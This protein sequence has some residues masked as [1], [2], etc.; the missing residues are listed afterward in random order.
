MVRQM[1][2]YLGRYVSRGRRAL[3]EGRAVTALTVFYG[4]ISGPKGAASWILIG[5]IFTACGA[6][7]TAQSQ[8]DLM[9]SADHATQAGDWNSC[10][11]D[12]G[13]AIS[14]DSRI[15]AAYLGRAACY[16]SRG[17]FGAAA[18]DYRSALALSPNDAG[19]Y[20]SR[21]SVYDAIGNKTA[22]AQDYREVGSL[23]SANP[24]QLLQAAQGLQAI[25][26]TTEAGSLLD[27]AITKYPR[28]A[29]L[30]KARADIHVL[31]GNT[32]LAL[33]E[34]SQALALAQGTDAASVL[35]DR[36]LY[37]LARNAFELALHDFDNALRLYTADYHTFEGRA[38]TR[39][40]LGDRKGAI[41]DLTAAIALAKDLP[42]A[43][44]W[45]FAGLLEARAAIY[46]QIR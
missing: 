4:R 22:A 34:W 9:A 24:D 19:L 30:H 8:Q 26:F 23:A 21:A 2:H 28:V 11:S 46:L 37:Y 40:A 33:K 38:R 36:G 20:L 42:S 41:S 32:D 15:V 14:S 13:K 31:L 39:L 1:S 7:V 35:A 29:G 5:L 45:R 27:S 18:A 44:W 10:I 43:D 17:D 25:G 3:D 6:G 12:Y 16:R